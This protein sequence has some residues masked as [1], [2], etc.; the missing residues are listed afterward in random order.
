MICHYF[1]RTCDSFQCSELTSFLIGF[2]AQVVLVY[3]FLNF[4]HNFGYG[5]SILEPLVDG[6]SLH[7]Q[8]CALAQK[9]YALL[10]GK[11]V[12]GIW[13]DFEAQNIFMDLNLRDFFPSILALLPIASDRIFPFVYRSQ[14]FELQLRLRVFQLLLWARWALQLAPTRAACVVGCLVHILVR[15]LPLLTIHLA[16]QATKSQFTCWVYMLGL[17]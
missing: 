10:C 17:P 14:I 3:H 12:Y 16:E 13:N 9:L 6:T 11:S 2:L 5:R 4:V 1:M 15:R 7:P 8:P